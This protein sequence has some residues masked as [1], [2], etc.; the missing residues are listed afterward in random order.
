[1]VAGAPGLLRW[2]YPPSSASQP[3]SAARSFSSKMTS[4][5]TGKVISVGSKAAKAPQKFGDYLQT[6]GV[7]AFEHPNKR[8]FDDLM[9]LA[10]I[11]S[12][13]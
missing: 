13:A 1:M 3:E 6:Q 9:F 11:C 12:Y 10:N 8:A 5:I 4:A 2:T 7:M